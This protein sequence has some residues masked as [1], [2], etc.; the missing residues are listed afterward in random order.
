MIKLI[1]Y[2]VND[3]DFRLIEFTA[4]RLTFE[5]NEGWGKTAKGGH[6]RVMLSQGKCA[7]TINAKNVLGTKVFDL[8]DEGELPQGVVEYLPIMFDEILAKLGDPYYQS[9][10]A[11][12]TWDRISPWYQEQY[13]ELV[14]LINENK[15][16]KEKRF[17]RE[18]ED[19]LRI[20]YNHFAD[21]TMWE[22]YQCEIEA[23]K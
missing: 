16:V 8:N 14:Y 5:P 2:L 9:M 17:N 3:V 11:D 22:W 15:D 12:R 19:D 13:D 21:P 20:F 10:V 6:I 1:Q 18:N 4:N 23:A 7:V